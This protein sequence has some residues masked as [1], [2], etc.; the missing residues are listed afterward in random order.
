MAWT[1]NLPIADVLKDFTLVSSI[2]RPVQPVCKRH[3]QR[4]RNA[5][6]VGH[7]KG[8]ISEKRFCFLQSVTRFRS[9]YWISNSHS[10]IVL[11]LFY[12][13]GSRM[14]GLSMVKVGC[15]FPI[16]RSECCISR[17]FGRMFDRHQ[18]YG[19]LSTCLEAVMIRT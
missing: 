15:G 13:F 10:I 8:M 7:T 4:G 19:N 6:R 14:L 9:F 17:L 12:G 5:L 16:W 1:L 18:G 11:R 3:T 2:S